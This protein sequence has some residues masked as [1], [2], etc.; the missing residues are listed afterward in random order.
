M[1]ASGSLAANYY[2]TTYAHTDVTPTNGWSWA[3]YF[4]GLQALY[5]QTSNSTY[6]NDGIAWGASNGWEPSTEADPNS[7]K[8]AQDYFDLHNA[9]SQASLTTVNAKLANDLA[10]Q[11]PS[12]YDWIDA[13][14][15]G[16]PD[17]PRWAA[18]TGDTAYLT[19]MDSFFAWTMNSGGTSSR[20]KGKTVSQAGLFS[21]SQGLWYRDC[22]FIDKLDSKGK[23]IF[24]SRGNGWVIA[25]MAQVI[26]ALPAGDPH[27][28]KYIS[29][30]QTMAASLAPLQGTDGLWRAS[31]KDTALYSSPETSGTALITYALAYGVKAGW[32][33][34]SKYSPIIALAWQGLS[35]TSLQSSGFLTDCQGPGSG[36]AAPY[37]SSK[38]KTAA[39]ATSAGTVDDNSPPFCVGA[40]LLASSQVAQLTK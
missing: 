39:T 20:C 17:Y 6:L 31:L 27:A 30:L 12:Q 38:P 25:A 1:L 14:F 2:R 40:F 35:K 37:T 18:Q 22:T 11:A 7:I 16:L 26:Q 32:L 33:S 8:S 19:K 24:W 34:S 10:N 5:L 9:S 23:P 3:T 15:M 28:A 13:L 21:A 36:P 29:M 4:N